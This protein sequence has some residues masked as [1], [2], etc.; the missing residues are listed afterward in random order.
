MSAAPTL[1]RT[2]G[3]IAAPIS[4]LAIGCSRLGSL[5]NTVPM[6]EMRR[7]LRAALDAGINVFDTANIYGQGDSERELGK[8]YGKREDVFLVTKGGRVFTPKARLMARLKPVLRPAVRFAGLREK[9]SQARGSEIGKDF[10]AAALKAS[11]E[12]SLRHLRREAVDAYL[13]HDPTPGDMAE[14]AC[15]Q[16]LQEA[17]KAGKV[18]YAG[19]SIETDEDLA[20]AAQLPDCDIL[21]APLDLLHRL[22]DTQSYRDLVARGTALFVRQILHAEAAGSEHGEPVS[23]SRGLAAARSLPGVTSTIVG[24]SSMAHLRALLDAA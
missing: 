2:E 6:A 23:V 9:A 3:S 21:Q 22:R 8:L 14:G 16:V 1:A 5:L 10:S 15:W 20:A 4:D 18:R 12:S 7:M 17:K 11:L 24:V 13:L 19:V